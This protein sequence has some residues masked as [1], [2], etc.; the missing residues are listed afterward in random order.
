[1]GRGRL[2]IG[3]DVGGGCVGGG[4]AGEV[5]F[6]GT[7]SQLRW[8]EGGSRRQDHQLLGVQVCRDE[9]Q[10]SIALER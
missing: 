2:V 6:V 4:C 3:H 1:M 8:E 9:A 10:R 7:G 5:G